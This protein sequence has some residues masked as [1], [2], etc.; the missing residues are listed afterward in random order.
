MSTEAPLRGYFCQISDATIS[1]G[2]HSS[3]VPNEK[4]PWG[5]NGVDTPC[6]M[7]VS[8]ASIVAPLTVAYVLGM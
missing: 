5:N 1:Y 6:Y 3:A 8:D 2:G 7:I 4:I